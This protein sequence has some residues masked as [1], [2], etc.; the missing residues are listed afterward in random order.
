M[1]RLLSGGLL[2][3]RNACWWVV[4]QG[5]R[6]R[7][8]IDRGFRFN[9]AAIQLY[10]NGRIVLAGESYIGESSTIQAGRGRAVRVGRCCQISHNVRIYTETSDP[11]SDFRKSS[12]AVIAADVEIGDGAWI[13]ANV[14]IGPG[15]SIG[16]N[17]VVGANSVV[18][19]S[20]PDDQIW[21]GVPLRFLR[22][23]VR[24]ADSP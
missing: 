2:R 20:V 15:V 12:G 23:K 17:S 22:A 4:Y 1:W 9:G 5:Y 3:L 13:G 8:E 11:D 10:G 21:G 16:S 6:H 24:A 7:Y 18:N 19:R 14:L